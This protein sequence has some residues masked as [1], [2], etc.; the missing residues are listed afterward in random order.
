MSLQ[1]GRRWP[2][3]CVV[4]YSHF[5]LA[6]SRLTLIKRTTVVCEG[7]VRREGCVYVATDT[8]WEQCF[9]SISSV[10]FR[11]Y[12]LEKVFCVLVIFLMA[13]L[14]VDHVQKL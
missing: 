5:A 9:F 7:F 6:C 10:H 14:I 8:V 3:V 1:F 11:R 13:S 2:E 12:V 4:V